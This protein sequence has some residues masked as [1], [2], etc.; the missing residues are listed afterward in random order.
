MDVPCGTMTQVLLDVFPPNGR[1][2][3]FS[4]DVEGS[5]HLVLGKALDLTKV[6]IEMLMIEVE[7]TFCQPGKDCAVR[8]KV[9][10]MMKEAGYVRFSKRIR[11]SDVFIRQ[12]SKLLEKAS[13]SGWVPI[14]D[15]KL[16][17]G[18]DDVNNEAGDETGYKA[19]YETGDDTGDE[20]A[21]VVAANSDKDR[22][23]Q[24]S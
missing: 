22:Q 20:T 8:N 19:G 10:E 17:D 9:R 11:A 7:N 14:V 18:E 5:E 2:S 12:G 6:R 15:E 1:V 23:Q 24:C 13:A 3:F 16:D 21:V 4:L